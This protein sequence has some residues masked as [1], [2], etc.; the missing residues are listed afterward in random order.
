MRS[1]ANLIAITAYYH[2][3]RYLPVKLCLLGRIKTAKTRIRMIML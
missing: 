1:A 2:D 3:N